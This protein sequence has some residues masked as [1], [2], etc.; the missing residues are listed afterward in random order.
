MRFQEVNISNAVSSSQLRAIVVSADEIN[1][2][3]DSLSNITQAIE[4]QEKNV[5][6]VLLTSNFNLKHVLLKSTDDHNVSQYPVSLFNVIGQAIGVAK[7]KDEVIEMWNG[8]NSN[9]EI[10]ILFGGENP[11]SFKIKLNP[12]MN[13]EVIVGN[14]LAELNDSDL[15]ALADSTT[16]TILYR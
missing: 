7:N 8:D 15:V 14:P 12:E 6:N 9:K 3:N 5:E 11:Y 10:G 4:V 2:Q 16:E 13:L 1:H